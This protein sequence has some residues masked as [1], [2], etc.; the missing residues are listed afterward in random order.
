MK[1]PRPSPTLTKEAEAI[2]Q[3]LDRLRTKAAKALGEQ[4]GCHYWDDKGPSEWRWRL[5]EGITATA[6]AKDPDV[7]IS[8]WFKGYTP[9]GIDR[10]ILARG[11]FPWADTTKAQEASAE[12]LVALNGSNKVDRND[13]SFHEHP[14]R[15]NSIEQ[16]DSNRPP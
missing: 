15:V 6:T 3:R 16:I 13:A 5:I 12:Y 7:D 1:S 9:L 14:A 11:V 10:P 2:Q 4:L 8:Q